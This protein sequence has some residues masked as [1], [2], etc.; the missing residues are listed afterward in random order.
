MAV[1]CSWR[2]GGAQGLANINLGMALL[3]LFIFGL[4]IRLIEAVAV[5]VPLLSILFSGYLG[6]EFPYAGAYSLLMIATHDFF[7]RR[8]LAATDNPFPPKGNTV[9]SI[10]A[11]KSAIASYLF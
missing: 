1:S 10:L 5:A 11:T 6:K 3:A 4:L 2:K 7:L 9:P 8:T